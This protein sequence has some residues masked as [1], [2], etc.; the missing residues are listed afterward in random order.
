MNVSLQLRNLAKAVKTK[1]TTTAHDAALYRRRVVCGLKSQV[2]DTA[3]FTMNHDEAWNKRSDVE[4][5][6]EKFKDSVEKSQD[7]Q[8]YF[9]TEASSAEEFVTYILDQS[10]IER[11]LDEPDKPLEERTKLPG[12]L[13]TFGCWV[14]ESKFSV[15]LLLLSALYRYNDF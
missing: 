7:L 12:M 13:R 11:P 6:L 8:N 10:L 4:A 5:S 9:N 2:I 1:N 15:L 14:S 3:F